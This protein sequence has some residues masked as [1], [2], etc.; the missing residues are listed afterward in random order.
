MVQLCDILTRRIS[1]NCTITKIIRK[2]IK[3][4]DAFCEILECVQY[5]DIKY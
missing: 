3:Y 1:H 2:L 5:D 4:G